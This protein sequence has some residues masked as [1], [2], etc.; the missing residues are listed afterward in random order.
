MILDR[1][2]LSKSLVTIRTQVQDMR[3]YAEFTHNTID[4][5]AGVPISLRHEVTKVFAQFI[6]TVDWNLAPTVA[7]IEYLLGFR[8]EFDTRGVDFTVEESI[9]FMKLWLSEQITEV[10]QFINDLKK[11]AGVSRDRAETVVY[12]FCTEKAAH[13]FDCHDVIVGE[14]DKLASYAKATKRQDALSKATS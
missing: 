9:H 6:L 8:D 1:P 3:E 4:R 13:I 7:R 10:R 14:L 5:N 11:R 12:V 2:Q